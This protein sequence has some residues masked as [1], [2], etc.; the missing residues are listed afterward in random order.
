M[1]VKVGLRACPALVS[2]CWIC[3]HR[4]HMFVKVGLRA[5]PALV[6]FRGYGTYGSSSVRCPGSP[7]T[8]GCL[9]TLNRE[10]GTFAM[11]ADGPSGV[12]SCIV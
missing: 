5:C 11:Q 7:R 2:L 3:A 6:G 1:F 9:E 10:R 4:A 12:A 8:F